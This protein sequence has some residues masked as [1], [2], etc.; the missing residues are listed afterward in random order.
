MHVVRFAS[1]EA[2]EPEPQWCRRSLCN[3]PEIAVEHFVKPP[4]HASPA[5]AHPSAQVLL[6][7]E[8]RLAL[9]DGQGREELLGPGDAAYIPGGEEHVVRN[10]LD[11]PSVGVDIFVP[12]RSFDFW[13]RRGAAERTA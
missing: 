13:T 5:H 4:R 11:T 3:A 7:L 6:V 2:Y 9:R 1:A 12:G 10:D 8:G